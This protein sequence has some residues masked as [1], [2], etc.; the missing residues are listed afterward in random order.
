MGPNGAVE[1]G[2]H[3]D[4][5]LPVLERLKRDVERRTRPSGDINEHVDM[6]R[7]RKKH[8]VS[9]ATGCARAA[10]L[11]NFGCESVRTMSSQPA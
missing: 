3:Q 10:A 5:V 11:A 6:W 1:F 2:V 4:D 9:V 8:R 7:P